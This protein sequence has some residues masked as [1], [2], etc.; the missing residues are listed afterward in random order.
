MDIVQLVYPN[1]TLDFMLRRLQSLITNHWRVATVLLV[2][3]IGGSVWFIQKGAYTGATLT[4]TQRDFYERVSVSG[5]VTAAKNVDLGFSAN[6]RIQAI[7]VAV[8]GRVSAG[9]VLA[10]TENGDLAALLTQAKANLSTVI[11]GTRPEELSVA[12]AAVTSAQDALLDA[13]HNAYTAADDSVHNKLDI[14]FNIAESLAVNPPEDPK[15][16]FRT[17]SDSLRLE[18]EHS[19]AAIDVVFRDWSL[20]EAALVPGNVMASAKQAQIYLGQVTTLLADANAAL[21]QSVADQRASAA[22][23]ATYAAALAS[24]RMSVNNA[25]T[26]LTAAMGSLDAA[27]KTLALK[28]AGSTQEAIAAQQAVVANAEAALGKTYVVA[29]FDGVVTRMDAKVGEVVSPSRSEISMQSDGVFQIETYVPEVSIARIAAGN[30]ATTTLDAYG[31][32][33]EFASVVIAV[34]PAETMRDGVPTYKTTLSFL[35]PDPRIR[36]GMTAD[37]RI[38]TGVLRNAVV[39]P[40]GA[41]GD[42]NGSPYVSV[43]HR[44]VVESRSVTLGPTPALG[45]AQIVSGLSDGEVI[46]LTPAR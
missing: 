22:T 4:I 38:Q 12:T 32:A 15:L 42:K 40:A 10:E 44:G 18:A 3:I 43:V 20:L 23:L 30:P 33:V 14:M 2:L 27:E 1:V 35:S 13:V 37:V 16:T 19:R 25:A 6:G 24:A 7:H 5:T 34:D 11:S 41:V 29:P 17:Q 45:Q 36:S 9:T 8:G 31:P 46:L 28:K 26:A 21:A 39:I